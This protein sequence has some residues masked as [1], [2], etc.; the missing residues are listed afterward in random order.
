MN[1]EIIISCAD[2]KLVNILQFLQHNGMPKTKIIA[3]D[4]VK[5]HISNRT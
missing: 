1:K 2:S 4:H 5:L 3:V